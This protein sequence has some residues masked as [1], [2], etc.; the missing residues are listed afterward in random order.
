MRYEKFSVPAA[1][2]PLAVATVNEVPADF[3]DIYKHFALPI[4][5]PAEAFV[6]NSWII[7]SVFTFV[8]EITNDEAAGI[9]K[10]PVVPP[11]REPVFSDAS[12]LP[13]TKANRPNAGEFSFR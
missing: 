11:V 4:S 6:A 5:V 7:E 13:E 2:A 10:F 9:A 8:L 3:A 12:N 1:L